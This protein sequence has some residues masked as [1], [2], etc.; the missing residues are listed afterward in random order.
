MNPQILLFATTPILGYA[1]GIFLL[2]Y[3]IQKGKELLAKH[4]IL[5][6]SR[7]WGV[8]RKIL[9]KENINIP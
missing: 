3:K 2:N 4:N 5:T 6:E 7:N 9:K 8:I 1:S